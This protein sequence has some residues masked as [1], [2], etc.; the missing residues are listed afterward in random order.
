MPQPKLSKEL[1]QQALDAATLHGSSEAAS[2]ALGL[3][4]NTM[5]GRLRAAE[6]Y[7]L[8]PKGEAPDAPRQL[9]AQIKRLE[10]ELKVAQQHG[11][12]LGIIKGVIGK[13]ATNVEEL[14]PPEWTI[15]PRDQES[16]PGVPTL[17]LSDLH[18]GEVVQPAQVNHVNK[19]NLAI[20]RERLKNC[21]TAAI[22]L[23][24]IISPKMDYPGIVV[25]LGGDMISGNIHEELTA[26][27]ELNTMPTV[28]D[29]YGE[30]IGAIDALLKVFPQVFL[31]CVTGNHGRDT[32][33]IWTK[34]RHATS[35]DWLLYRFLA[36]HYD[37]DKRVTFYIPDGYAAYYR[38]Y[39][40]RYWLQH[41]D[42]FRGG[43]GII[44]PLGPIIR[45]DH[46]TRSR[47]A[48]IDMDYDT[49][50]IGHWHSYIHLGRLIVN[51][52][53]KGMDEYAFQNGF[54]FEVPSQALWLTHPRYGITYRMPVFVDRPRVASKTPWVSIK[55]NT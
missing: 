24:K 44:G 39:S 31:P 5:A 15:T 20:A 34:D 7:G 4:K 47:N 12:E 23:L 37:G 2:R 43:D 46:R 16:A 18:W 6:R 35:F 33:K 48:Q 51:S 14:T 32:R 53:L 49:M 22:H 9:K 25:P 38:I 26:T 1:A 41:G 36:K 21:I 52:S 11:D 45:G 3:P 27:N 30:L 10:A 55:E 17:M 54:S 40:H 28:L 8:K 50:L 42:Q 19:F 13:L 29:L